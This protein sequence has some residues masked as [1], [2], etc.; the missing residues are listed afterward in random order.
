[1]AIAY[2]GLGAN[3]GNPRETLHAAIGWL[4]Q[5]AHVTLRA[6]S[7]FYRSA[8][9][10]ASG[11]DYY[12]CALALE[13]T[14]SPFQ[15]L[16]VCAAG[17]DYFGRRRSYRNA[18]RTLD[19]DILLYDQLSL[20]SANLIIPHPRLTERAFVLLPLLE[21]NADFEIPQ[22]GRADAFLPAVA[23][24][25][26]DKVLDKNL[27]QFDA[28]NSA[29]SSST[30]IHRPNMDYLAEP[31][32]QA[33]T[34]PHLQIM[35]EKAEK[36]AVLTCYDASFAA[37][38]DQ[39]GVDVLLIGDSLGNVIQ[40][41]AT[42]LPVT[43]ADIAYHTACV[44]RS[45]S[46]ALI[47]AD[48]PF[49]SYATPSEAFANAVTL[50]RAGAQMVKLEGGMWLSDTVRFLVD[51]SI[52][53][54]AHIGLTPQS[55][56]ALGGFKVQGKTGA[57]AKQ[58]LCDAQALQQ[59]G[60]QLLVIEAV[61]TALGA[62]LTD[63]LLIPTIGIG[64]GPNCSGQVLV[65]YDLLGVSS[66]KSPRFAKNFVNEQ[67]QQTSNQPILQAAVETYVREVKMGVFPAAE[68]TF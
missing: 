35:R 40:G 63:A 10:Q 25:R 33:I 5:Q 48:L 28:P 11:N 16:A 46:R 12:N 58:L 1:M 20:D 67:A 22:R 13:T 23:A 8:P 34:V 45:Q 55:V 17:E 4:A 44:A 52:P 38:L 32:R 30:F 24:Q 65:L 26:I 51:R 21:L 27:I 18:P 59:A 66:G 39:A 41:H 64:A 29:I 54:C 3:L 42:T 37:L 43:V 9:V 6:L 50:M 15:L 36:I 19:I 14:L 62:Q 49:G 61:P 53:V 68:H 31:S 57:A 2:L 56:H 47:V 7:S 60:A